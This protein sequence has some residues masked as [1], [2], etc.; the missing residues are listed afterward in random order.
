MEEKSYPFK[1]NEWIKGIYKDKVCI[2]RTYMQPILLTSKRSLR[3]VSIVTEN[4]EITHIHISDLKN[5]V[6][7]KI[8]TNQ[9]FEIKNSIHRDFNEEAKS[10]LSL[11]KILARR[12]LVTKMS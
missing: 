10:P 11:K 7:L 2:G 4:G 5:V 3:F 1:A 8:L 9:E 6:Q 12:Q